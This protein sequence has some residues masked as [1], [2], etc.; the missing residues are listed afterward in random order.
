MER[1]F[2]EAGWLNE[3]IVK[4][5]TW[6]NPIPNYQ[7]GNVNGVFLCSNALSQI[8]RVRKS[9]LALNFAKIINRPQTTPSTKGHVSLKFSAPFT[10]AVHNS[11]P[12]SAQQLTKASAVGREGIGYIECIQSSKR[13]RGLPLKARTQLNTTLTTGK[14][15]GIGL[16]PQP[17]SL[18]LTPDLA[19]NGNQ[20][21]TQALTES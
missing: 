9:H 5:F 7:W 18:L 12:H 21:K 2:A 6:P 20:R 17:P 4:Q 15:W 11:T 1:N 19:I 16:W 14:G 3:L 10:V 8:L 13:L